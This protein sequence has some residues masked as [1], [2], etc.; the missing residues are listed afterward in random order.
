MHAISRALVIVALALTTACKT[1]EGDFTTISTQMWDHTKLDG[2]RVQQNA[3][4]VE[5]DQ[6]RHWFL[7]IPLG[8]RIS[9]EDVLDE[10]QR[11]HNGDVVVDCVVKRWWWTIILYSRSGCTATGRVFNTHALSLT[12]GASPPPANR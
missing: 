7:F 4:I 5:A 1:R 12:P 10:L 3:V 2:A 11:D 6:Y 9:V 8:S